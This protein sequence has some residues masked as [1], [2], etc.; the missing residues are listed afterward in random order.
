MAIRPFTLGELIKNTADELRKA[1]D[2]SAGVNPVMQFSGC[3]IELAATV[4]AEAGGGI[5]FWLIDASSKI[6]GERVS[7]VKLSFGPIPD[8]AIQFKQVLIDDDDVGPI[9]RKQKRK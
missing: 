3:E 9:A 4:S 6:A 2:A 8:K 7:T 1:Y 5:K